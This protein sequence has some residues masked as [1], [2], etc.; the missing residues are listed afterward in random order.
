MKAKKRASADEIRAEIQRRIEASDALGGDCR[1]SKAPTP[2]LADP[3][4]NDGCNWTI[5]IVPSYIPGCTGVV[6]EIVRQVM[7]EYDLAP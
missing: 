7:A 3:A 6:A 1:E 2:M 4:Q 5:N